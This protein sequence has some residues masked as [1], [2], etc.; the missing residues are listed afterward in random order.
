MQSCQSKYGLENCSIKSLEHTGTQVNIGEQSL[1][2]V[3]KE[4]M[5]HIEV[6]GENFLFQLMSTC[7]QNIALGID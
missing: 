2:V 5:T 1:R 4:A 6:N 3:E 7:K